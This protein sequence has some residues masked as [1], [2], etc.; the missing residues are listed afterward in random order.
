MKSVWGNLPDAAVI[1]DHFHV[2][3]LPIDRLEGMRRA[4]FAQG[5]QE[6][7]DTSR[8]SRRLLLRNE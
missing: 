3:R 8:G 4:V 2:V 7:K 5:P 6:V 1:I